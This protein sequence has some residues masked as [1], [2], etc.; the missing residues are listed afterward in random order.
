MDFVVGPILT[1]CIISL[2]LHCNKVLC[3]EDWLLRVFIK[4]KI[5]TIIENY[6]SRIGK[7][8]GFEI[9]FN[10]IMCLLA[11]I[12]YCFVLPEAQFT[13]VLLKGIKSS[14]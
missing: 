8:Y 3:F 11:I 7:V 4:L 13:T 5:T 1:C 14:W 10:A 9:T 2:P 12:F 6:R